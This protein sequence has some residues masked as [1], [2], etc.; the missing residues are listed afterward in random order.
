M[1][2]LT[3]R[4]SLVSVG[5]PSHSRGAARTSGWWLWLREGRGPWH[6]TQ[7]ANLWLC[8]EDTGQAQP[9]RSE[10]R[11]GRTDPHVSRLRPP[12]CAVRSRRLAFSTS[13]SFT[14][15]NTPCK[16]TSPDS[17]SA[18]LPF[19]LLNPSF[20]FSNYSQWTKKSKMGKKR[21]S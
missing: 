17:P 4:L 5:K 6:M 8:R 1:R 11:P 2:F 15:S 10:P 9:E 16:F 19:S 12:T 7:G 13:V 21:F 18:S 20:P 14:C 3:P